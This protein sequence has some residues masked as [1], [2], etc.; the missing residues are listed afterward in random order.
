MGV[1][2]KAGNIKPNKYDLINQS[3]MFNYDVNYFKMLL[4]L[5]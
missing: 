5:F 3:V 2:L 4:G 1:T